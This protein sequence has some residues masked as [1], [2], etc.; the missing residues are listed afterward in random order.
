[1]HPFKTKHSAKL[2]QLR[3]SNEKIAMLTCYDAT[4]A[5]LSELAGVDVLLVGDSL[6]MVL[7]GGENTLDVL[8]TDMIYHTR[9]VAIGA[10]NTYIITDMPYSSYESGAEIAYENAKLLLDAG[11]HMVKLE[12]GGNMVNIVRHLVEKG[13]P[14]CAHLG[15][16]PQ[17]IQ[18]LGGYRIQG[19]T[20]ESAKKIMQD[21]IAMSEAGVSFILLE[22]VPASLARNITESLDTPTIGIGAGVD[23][24][25]QVL[26]LHDLLGIYTGQAHKHPNEFRSPRFVR[27][28]L[29]DSDSIQAAVETYVKA[30]KNRSFPAAEHSY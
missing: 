2:E 25:G 4:F 3:Q 22:M 29:K 26:V 11:A 23:C 13:I 15:F 6:G 18:Q 9:C 21:A 1:M 14:V 28:F 27:N 24:S 8:M 30:V 19:K 5:K 12:G 17:S 10:P 20:E 7:Q 16:T